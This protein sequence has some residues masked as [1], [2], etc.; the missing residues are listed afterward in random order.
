VIVLDTHVLIWWRSAPSRLSAPAQAVI[1][2]ARSIG[3]S[4]ISCWETAM[5][6]SRGR[7]ALDREVD[8][9]LQQ[10]LA[11]IA[12]VDV[13]CDVAAAAGSMDVERFLGDPAD[14]LILATARDRGAQ[15]VTADRALLKYAPD[16]T[17]W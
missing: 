4:A 2:S 5:L 9:W 1:R 6:V 3:V 10:A 8:V 11:D 14:R 16:D 13:T 17:I 15:L 7:I 12:V